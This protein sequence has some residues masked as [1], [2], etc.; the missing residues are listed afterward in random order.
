MSQAV[1]I[2]LVVVA[3]ILILLGDPAT[4][5]EH[6]THAGV[7]LVEGHFDVVSGPRVGSL[8]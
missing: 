7:S 4:S 1:L 8:A 3:A 6:E 2:E 5:V